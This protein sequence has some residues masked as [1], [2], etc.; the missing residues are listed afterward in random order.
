MRAATAQQLQDK[1]KIWARNSEVINGAR[2]KYA[3]RTRSLLV[4]DVIELSTFGL[5]Y[6]FTYTC[7]LFVQLFVELFAV[8]NLHGTYYNSSWLA[9]RVSMYTIQANRSK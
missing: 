7:F 1:I 2:F 4:P 6:C 3:T 9:S 5:S 8:C